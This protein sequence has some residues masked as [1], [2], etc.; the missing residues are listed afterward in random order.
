MVSGSVIRSTDL[1]ITVGG[2]CHEGVEA[3]VDSEQE[4]VPQGET[5]GDIKKQKGI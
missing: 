1:L 5:E 2:V 4:Q 3:E